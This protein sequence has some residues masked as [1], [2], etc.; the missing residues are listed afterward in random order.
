ML[1]LFS[2]RAASLGRLACIILFFGLIIAITPLGSYQRALGSSGNRRMK[3]GPHIPTY[4][5]NFDDLRHELSR[6]PCW[7][8]T[9]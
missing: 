1:I 8:I 2:P 3:E 5:P 6:D 7:F 4:L 9:Y